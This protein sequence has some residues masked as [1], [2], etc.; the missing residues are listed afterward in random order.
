MVELGTLMPDFHLPDVS[1]GDVV[2]SEDFEGKE[3]VLVIFLC[4]HCP[5]VRHVA[6]ELA[7][8]GKYYE[9]S[10]LG[11][12]AISSNDAE[13]YPEDNPEN[14]DDMGQ[15]YDFNFP[16]LYDESQDVARDYTASCTP[17]FFLFNKKRELVYRGQ[18]DD[19]RPDNGKAV[20]GKDLREA[21]DKVLAGRNPDD[22]QIPSSGCSIKWK[23]G[24][25]PPYYKG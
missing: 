7:R 19:S 22:K 5:Y 17:D 6:D 10:E 12:V 16:I 15:E 3:A 21:I 9:G 25:E 14:L 18:L 23:V 11:I 1:T 13:N 8:I 24:N 2:S 4:Q 20:T